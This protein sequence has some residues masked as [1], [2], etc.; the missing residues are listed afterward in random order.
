MGLDNKEQL[1][2]EPTPAEIAEACRDLLEAEVCDE[3]AEQEET[4]TALGLAFSAI[5][6]TGEDPEEYLKN[7]GILE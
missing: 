1:D 3:I 4:E 7:K 5:L 2:E 6:E